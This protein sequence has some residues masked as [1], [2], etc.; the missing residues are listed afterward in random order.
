VS[1]SEKNNAITSPRNFQLPTWDGIV[2]K[3]ASTRTEAQKE[4]ENHNSKSE[5]DSPD[6]SISLKTSEVAIFIHISQERIS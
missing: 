3:L 4:M 5:N 2:E 6:P 1:I